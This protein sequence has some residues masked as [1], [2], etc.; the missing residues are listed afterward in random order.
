MEFELTLTL[1][2]GQ[3]GHLREFLYGI[4]NTIFFNRVFSQ[5]VP[6]SDQFLNQVE[7]PVVEDDPQ[8]TSLVNEKLDLIV[9]SVPSISNSRLSS[10]TS[11]YN[12]D[13]G[14]PNT[15]HFKTSSNIK[16]K[17]YQN[18]STDDNDTET[19]HN[20]WE[21]WNIKV[22][23]IQLPKQQ[24]PLSS[25]ST[26]G[27][28][29]N[30]S[31][32]KLNKM[33]QDEYNKLVEMFENNLFNII[34]IIDLNKYHIPPITSFEGFPYLIEVSNDDLDVRNSSNESNTT[35]IK[36]NRLG[37]SNYY[38]QGEEILKSGFKFIKKM[39]SD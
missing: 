39:L 4:I 1:T 32:A 10:S 15:Q 31:T 18:K 20:C 13:S 25:Q 19:L 11:S 9:S 29:I 35:N 26:G 36:F 16:I 24:Q 3:S 27:V 23:I 5:I 6:S 38:V 37:P 14:D 33:D 17:F 8:L 34:D 22:I 21:I 2:Q 30:T 7:Y 12:L 28:M